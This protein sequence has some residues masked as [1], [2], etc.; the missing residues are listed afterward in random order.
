MTSNDVYDVICKHLAKMNDIRDIVVSGDDHDQSDRAPGYITAL[1]SKR[2]TCL[3]F[4]IHAHRGTHSRSL[5]SFRD[6]L[7]HMLYLE[8]GQ[9]MEPSKISVNLTLALLADRLS[10]TS[11]ADQ[12]LIDQWMSKNPSMLS[13][14]PDKTKCLAELHWHDLPS[15]L[16]QDLVMLQSLD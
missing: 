16:F 12:P 11:V 6:S 9:L 3:Y 15:E 10:T 1:I 8:T 4:A 5:L 14:L 2:I 7:I 13:V